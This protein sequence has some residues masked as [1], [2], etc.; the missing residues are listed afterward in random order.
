MFA[1]KSAGPG[2]VSINAAACAMTL[3]MMSMYCDSA[4]AQQPVGS[5]RQLQAR[6]V[7]LRADLERAFW[8]CDYTATT[9]GMHATPVDMCIAVT[10]ELKSEKFGGDFKEM[11]SWWQQNKFAEHQKLKSG[12]R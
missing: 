7:V 9:R 5:A 2:T 4:A 3:A 1:E 11:L 8:M 12:G 6:A 10:D